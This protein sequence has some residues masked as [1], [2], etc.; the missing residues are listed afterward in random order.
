MRKGHTRGFGA[1]L[2]GSDALH[3]QSLAQPAEKGK[4]F[5]KMSIGGPLIRRLR[6]AAGH[7]L[8]GMPEDAQ[9]FAAARM[10][11]TRRGA[12]PGGGEDGGQNRI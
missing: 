6:R 10:V 7:E 8:G 3:R 12:D 11:Q 4:D 2:R 1:E 9:H 5:F